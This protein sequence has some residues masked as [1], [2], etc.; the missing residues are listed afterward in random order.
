MGLANQLK[1]QCIS[2]FFDYKTLQHGYVKLQLNHFNLYLLEELKL[3]KNP[4]QWAWF[5]QIGK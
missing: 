1:M 4:K 5:E 2:Y 3:W